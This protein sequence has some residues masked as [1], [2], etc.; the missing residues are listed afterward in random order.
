MMRNNF[1]FICIIVILFCF[2]QSAIACSVPYT[3]S[4]FA[5]AD[6]VF[7]GKVTNVVTSQAATVDVVSYK[8]GKLLNKSDWYWEKSVYK[9]LSAS[10]EVS[11]MFKGISTK[12]IEVYTPVFDDYRKDYTVPYKEG[13][14][15]LVYAYKRRTLLS[16]FEHSFS[17]WQKPEVITEADK[18]NEQLPLFAT[19][20]CGGTFHIKHSSYG[21]SEI[22]KV[23]SFA[24]NGL[25]KLPK[26]VM[27]P[28]VHL[29]TRVLY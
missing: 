17:H 3:G 19:T 20:I 29:P 12:T 25:P 16:Y 5:S 11:E 21:E 24:K 1:V 7:V 9:V 26:G 10:I 15:F 22:K 27:K 18:F 2:S 28:P 4:A 8:S 6:A 14:S 23:R 13:E